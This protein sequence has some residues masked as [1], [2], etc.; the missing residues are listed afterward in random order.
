MNGS[1][2]TGHWSSMPK[3]VDRASVTSG[4]V[5]GVMRSTIELGN[6]VSVRIHSAR[7]GSFNSAYARNIRRATSPLP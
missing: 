3:R 5:T 6:D 1:A 4:V 7:S 2:A